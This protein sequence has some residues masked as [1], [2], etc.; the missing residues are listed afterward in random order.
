MISDNGKG[1]PQDRSRLMEPYVTNRPS[2]TGLGLSIV[3]KT[4]EEHGGSFQLI[5]AQP[6][7]REKTF[8]A[9]A[10]I[11]LPRLAQMKDSSLNKG[12]T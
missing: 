8:G 4:I 1:L 2:G 10:I 9:K 6:F 7:N 5:D 3:L 12:L 11:K